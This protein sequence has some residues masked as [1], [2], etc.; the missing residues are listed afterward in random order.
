MV[1]TI[2]LGKKP[3]QFFPSLGSH[4]EIFYVA[5]PWLKVIGQEQKITIML[6]GTRL[7]TL[8]YVYIRYSGDACL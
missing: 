2:A 8:L 1:N 7:S 4:P 5:S 3:L 6:F